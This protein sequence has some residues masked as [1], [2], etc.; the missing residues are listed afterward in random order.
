MNDTHIFALFFP[1]FF[2]QE[3]KQSEVVTIDDELI[4]HRIKN[5]LR[6]DMQDSCIFFDRAV[7]AKVLIFS[8]SKKIITVQIQ[9]IV[10]N[11]SKLSDIVFLLP[12]LKKDNLETAVYG[13]AELGVANIQLV[14]T[15][16]SRQSL[17]SP[18]EFERLQGIV[19]AAAEQSKNYCFSILHKPVFLE[20]FFGLDQATNDIF[21][22]MNGRSFF[23]ICLSENVLNEQKSYRLL[24]GP[25]A[26]LM[27]LEIHLLKQHK[28]ISCVL[29]NTVLRSVQACALGAGLFCLKSIKNQ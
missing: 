18:K 17:I 27:D 14:V 4:V 2:Q 23:E 10:E 28:W 21:F 25:E 16:K 9:E 19:V 7:H 15:Q 6:F 22:D 29:T 3:R 1:L 24:I 13:L 8:I 26:G 11:K 20:S 5:V 12:L